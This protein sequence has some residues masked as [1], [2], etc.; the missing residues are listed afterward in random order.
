MAHILYTIVSQLHFHF[1]LHWIPIIRHIPTFHYTRVYFNPRLKH[2]W[3]P[4]Q[5]TPSLV[6]CA[7]C[8]LVSMGRSC[9]QFWLRSEY[10]DLPQFSGIL[11]WGDASWIHW[12][13]CSVVLH[14]AWRVAK[15]MVH[16]NEGSTFL[17]PL[18]CWWFE[19]IWWFGTLTHLVLQT[20]V[21]RTRLTIHLSPSTIENGKSFIANK[22]FAEMSYRMFTSYPIFETLWGTSSSIN[23]WMRIP[24]CERFITHLYIYIYICIY[25]HKIIITTTITI[26]IINDYKIN[27]DNSIVKTQNQQ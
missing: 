10:W 25:I 17:G 7:R 4:L 20:T 23:P 16:K 26:T 13:L 18:V 11:L 22:E 8:L 24:G 27:S 1:A 21:V 9:R 19:S 6:S 3:C 15:K 5:R 12:R 2:I 14:R